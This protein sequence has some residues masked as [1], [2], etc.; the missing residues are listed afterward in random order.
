[1]RARVVAVAAVALVLT[2]A[3]ATPA[4]A[5]YVG[6]RPPGIP[7]GAEG[8][9]GVGPGGEAPGGLVPGGQRPRAVRLVA[10]ELTAV[11]VLVTGAELAPP[12]VRV[13][14]V[15]EAATAVGGG[16][17]VTGADVAQ[18]VLIAG[19]LIAVGVVMTRAARRRP[20]ASGAAAP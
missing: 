9:G 15:T 4:S 8:P 16:F 18:L 17:A 6:G 10:P 20:G 5:Q 1:M 7:P 19:S 3:W 11:N 13:V 12:R 14:R 2:A